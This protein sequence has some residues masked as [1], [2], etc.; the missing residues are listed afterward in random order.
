MNTSP[1][2]VVKHGD[3][4]AQHTGATRNLPAERGTGRAWRHEPDMTPIIAAQMHKES[5]RTW[6]Q[7]GA[8]EQKTDLIGT[9][10][11]Q[12]VL[13]RSGNNDPTAIG[14]NTSAVGIAG[15]G[16]DAPASASAPVSKLPLIL[17]GLALVAG[18][19]L[20]RKKS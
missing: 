20:L 10:R 14:L 11:S 17:G 15:F 12:T 5:N 6:G 3:E 19:F 4:S 9:P 2:S 7:S 18:F 13:V 1:W 8:F 16:D